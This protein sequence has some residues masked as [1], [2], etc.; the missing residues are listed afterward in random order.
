MTIHTESLYK[1]TNENGKVLAF[2]TAPDAQQCL[3]KYHT[4]AAGQT[5]GI[6]LKV[7]RLTFGFPMP[8][9]EILA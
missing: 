6:C 2:I 5:L 7:E 1:V 8:T 3:R 9:L 4:N